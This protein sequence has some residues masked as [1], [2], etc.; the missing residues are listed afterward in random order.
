MEN[1]KIKAACLTNAFLVDMVIFA[2]ICM[3]TG[4]RFMPGDVILETTKIE[5]FKFFTVDS[6][7]LLGIAAF[8]LMIYQLKVYARKIEEIP[9]WVYLLKLSATGCVTLTLMVTACYLAPFSKFGYFEFFKNSNLFFHFLVPVVSIISF[10]FL[11]NTNKIKF[12]DTFV[13]VIPVV[14]YEIYYM[15]N[16]FTHLENGKTTPQYDFYGFVKGGIGSIVVV[17]VL[18]LLITFIFDIILYGINKKLY[19]EKGKEV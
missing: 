7:I 5:M 11:D 14:I 8:I 16:V 4:F 3:F 6:N 1:K 10:M 12:K 19:K 9:K 17:A 18:I 2:S 13:C 15:I